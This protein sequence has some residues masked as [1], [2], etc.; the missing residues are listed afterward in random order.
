MSDEAVASPRGVSNLRRDFA[1]FMKSSFENLFNPKPERDESVP[2]TVF[3]H[4]NQ[5]F[6]KTVRDLENA[7]TERDQVEVIERLHEHQAEVLN[8]MEVIFADINDPRMSREY[9]LKFPA[10]VQGELSGNLWETLLFAAELISD[11]RVLEGR[12][13]ATEA[14]R[15]AAIALCN[16]FETANQVLRAQ[17]KRDPTK[18]TP[19]IKHTL[20]HFDQC[21]TTFENLYVRAI[22]PCKSSSEY[23]EKQDL[24]VLFSEA[25]HESLKKGT[26]TQEDIDDYEPKVMFTI[27]RLAVLSGLLLKANSVGGYSMMK[28]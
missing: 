16:A 17:A 22:V 18:Y 27:P 25:V 26:V 21:W 12:E 2:L 15:P 3:F 10:E 9:R 7:T 28:P 13:R 4:A 5:R 20:M 19:K 8:A 23:E 24:T 11:G 1:S 6:R 14:L